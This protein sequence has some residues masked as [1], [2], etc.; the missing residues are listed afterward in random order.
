MPKR[1]EGEPDSPC[2][3]PGLPG[4]PLLQGPAAAS[5][6]AGPSH[7]QLQADSSLTAMLARMLQN[8]EA[9]IQQNALFLEAHRQSLIATPSPA[10]AAPPVAAP[11]GLG[12]DGDG[13]VE[14]DPNGKNLAEVVSSIKERRKIS[15]NSS[16]KL[17]AAGAKLKKNFLAVARSK[18]HVKK[19]EESLKS[20]A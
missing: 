15:G 16:S 6:S 10:M 3:L 9:L 7:Q 11:P 20:L 18:E 1:H 4:F 13:D 19:Y 12:G 2:S 8:Q 14:I 5:S 17:T